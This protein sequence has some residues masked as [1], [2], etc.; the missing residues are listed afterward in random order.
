MATSP[1]PS[2]CWIKRW[3]K[4]PVKLL[5]SALWQVNPAPIR[6]MIEAFPGA[7]APS[8]AGDDALVIANFSKGNLLGRSPKQVHGGEGAAISTRG[9][10]APQKE[11]IALFPITMLDGTSPAAPTG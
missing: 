8:R 7:H 10:C 2:N 3:R 11:R 4:P 6:R 9:A 5:T 1:R